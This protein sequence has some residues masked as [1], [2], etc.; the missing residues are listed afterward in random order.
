MSRLLILPTL[1]LLAALAF[2]CGGDDNRNGDSPNQGGNDA[3]SGDLTL[4]AKNNLFD[5][6][7]L[8]APADTEVTLTFV[9]EDAG[10]VHNFALYE[11]SS[12]SENLYRGDIFPGVETRTET[13]ETPP[14]GE[15]YFRCDAHPDTMNGTFITE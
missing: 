1:F 12:A 7:T 15:Y 2:A 9:N 6:D 8:T 3:P 14:A 10:V 11:D 5:K 13:F 4:T